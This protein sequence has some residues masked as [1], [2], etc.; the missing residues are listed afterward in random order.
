MST[1]INQPTWRPTRKHFL[2]MLTGAVTA[3]VQNVANIYVPG[4]IFED[5]AVM[6]LLPVAV[7]YGISYLV[8]EKGT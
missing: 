3:V 5:P 7:G 1:Y 6:S 2:G 4:T 8:K